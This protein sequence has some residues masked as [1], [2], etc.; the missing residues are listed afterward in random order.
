MKITPEQLIKEYGPKVSRACIKMTLDEKEA[1]DLSQEVWLRVTQ[2]LSNFRG[3]SKI[4]TW[5][6]GITR[7]VFLEHIYSKKKNSVNYL[8]EKYQSSNYEPPEEKSVDEKEWAFS[9][10]DKCLTCTLSLLSE[11]ERIVF[12]YRDLLNIS[13]EEIS[14]ITKD[15]IISLRKKVS[16]SR[17]KIREVLQRVCCLFNEEDDVKCGMIKYVKKHK[18]LSEFKQARQTLKGKNLY[19]ENE[20]LTPQI[21]YWE[22]ML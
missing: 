3:E 21:N 1:D 18:L 4:S 5:I 14:D 17:K 2:N 11:E 8:V 10:C 16:R 9:M 20:I 22:K 13:Y 12:I 6:Y 19:Q 15:S 7:N